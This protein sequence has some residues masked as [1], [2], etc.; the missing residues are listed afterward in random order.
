MS[1]DIE[2]LRPLIA[3]AAA[4]LAKATTAAEVLDVFAKAKVHGDAAASAAR[5]AKATKAHATVIAACHKVKGDA[6]VIEAQ[7]QCRI[8]NEYDAAQKRGDVAVT[9]DNQRGRSN[10]ERPPTAADVG[11]TRK[12]VHEARAVRDAEKAKPGIVKKTVEAQLAAGEEPTRSNM[13]RAIEKVRFKGGRKGKTS[14]RTPAI[15]P[16]VEVAMGRGVL[17]E[18]KTLEQVV[19]DAGVGSVQQAK[20]AVAK[21]Q[22]RR[23]PKV[24]RSDL[25]L[26]AQAK[27]DAAINAYKVKL[28]SEFKETVRLEVLRICNEVQFPYW[29]DQIQKLNDSI[30]KLRSKGVMTGD[31]FKMIWTCLHADSRNSVSDK[32]LNEAFNMFEGLRL[33]L[34]SAKEVPTPGLPDL[35]DTLAEWDKMKARAKAERRKPIVNVMARR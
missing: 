25:S 32:K 6:L 7:A 4:A 15:T 30:E 21:E 20:I 16:A 29:R 17:D 28:A 26:T 11:L 5:F 24:E 18:G 2:K 9:G 10:G 3:Q 22:G 31:Q 27:F 35:P 13:K 34:V 23:E 8:A 12:L 14:R 19:A 33:M 1:N